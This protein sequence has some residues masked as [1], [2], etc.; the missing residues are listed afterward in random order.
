MATT[1]KFQ[2]RSSDAWDVMYADCVAAKHSIDVEQFILQYEPVTRKFFELF[3]EKA[4]SG[5]RVRLL[6]DMV[7]SYQIYESPVVRDLQDAGVQMQ[8]VHPISAWRVLNWTSWFF[9]DHGKLLVV[10]GVVAHTG[11]IGLNQATA[12]WRDT[13][14]RLIGPVV[15]QMQDAYEQMWQSVKNDKPIRKR[16][17]REFV[18][19]FTFLT[20]T[21]WFRSRFFYQNL[22]GAIKRARRSIYLATPYFVPPIRL[23]RRLRQAARRGVDVQLLLPMSSDVHVVDYA[24]RSYF[25]LALKSGI[26]IYRYRKGMMHAK[27]GIIDDRWATV[28]S[29]NLDNL[30]FLFNHE[31]NIVTTNRECIEELT[32]Q[33]FDDLE[34]SE[35]VHW[36]IW[37]N[38]FLGW[39]I[40]ELLTWPIHSLL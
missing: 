7:G 31:A 25:T 10:D 16:Q 35:E 13:N 15:E 27:I 28:G 20:D 6:C 1:W 39:K 29:T 14:I 26:R 4:R 40:L 9:R 30:S 21:P 12:A 33:F 18:E 17:S 36:G 3:V 11:G 19:G 5:V 23:F 38:R 32:R 2:L 37:I 8:F 34:Q 24:M 22:L